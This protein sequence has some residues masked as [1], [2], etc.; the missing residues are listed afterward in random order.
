MTTRSPEE[1]LAELWCAVFGEPPPL[2]S[3]PEVLTAILVDCLP[4]PAPY[5][6][7]QPPAAFDAPC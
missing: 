7:D 5:R 3:D 6:P 1:S 4:A 2:A